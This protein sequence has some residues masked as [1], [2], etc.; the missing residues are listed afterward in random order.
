HEV[1]KIAG[2]AAYDERNELVGLTPSNFVFG[3]ARVEGL[4]V[5]VGVDSF[6]VRGGSADATIKG[7]HLMCERMANELRLPLIRL[8]EGSG[9][10]GSGE[11]NETTG[12]GNL[13][14]VN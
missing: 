4:P 7:K 9:G 13:S 1:G 10:G 6:T 2:R 14:G 12:R 5:V 11:T 3:R 8:V